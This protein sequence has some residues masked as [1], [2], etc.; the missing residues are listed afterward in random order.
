VAEARNLSQ[1]MS[2]RGTFAGASGDQLAL[3]VAIRIIEQ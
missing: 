1:V 3:P 2:I